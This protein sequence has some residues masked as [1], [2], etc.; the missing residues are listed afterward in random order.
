MQC[1]KCKPIHA[2]FLYWFTPLELHPVTQGNIILTFQ[3]F[4]RLYNL[5]KIQLSKYII[6][7]TKTLE[8]HKKS[9]QHNEKL[10]C[11]SR[12]TPDTP[13]ISRLNIQ[14]YIL[15]LTQEALHL[16]WNLLVHYI[17]GDVSTWPN[18]WSNSSW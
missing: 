14:I 5:Y 17:K 6:Q 9:T 12:I 1:R 10:S 3:Y 8:S 2:K 16:S 4:K 15:S 13:Q 7:H 11:R 18:K